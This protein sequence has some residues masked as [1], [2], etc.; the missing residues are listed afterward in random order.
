MYL[1]P[2]LALVSNI[3]NMTI[4]VGFYVLP[5]SIFETGIILGSVIMILVSFLSYSTCCFIIESI[6]RA[7]L[8]DY[9]L[10]YNS[11]ISDL[12]CDSNLNLSTN[13]NIDIKLNACK[14]LNNK[15]TLDNTINKDLINNKKLT[16]YFE[17]DMSIHDAKK[18]TNIVNSYFMNKRIEISELSYKAFKGGTLFYVSSFILTMYLYIGQTAAAL[19]FSNILLGSLETI[20]P[21]LQKDMLYYTLLFVYYF[22]VI[23]LSLKTIDELGKFSS[24]IL[25]CR[26]VIFFILLFSMFWIITNYGIS[27]INKVPLIR[28][29]NSTLML[30]NC[31]FL[32]MLQHSVPGMVYGFKNNKLLFSSF[33][34]GVFISVSVLILYSFITTISFGHH[35]SCDANVFPSAIRNYFNLNFTQVKL[36][37]FFVNFNAF[38][39]IITGAIGCI[40]LTNN[41]KFVYSKVFK[42]KEKSLNNEQNTIIQVIYY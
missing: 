17:I 3:V 33:L 27:P 10:E 28:P 7:N 30:G 5:F 1:S 25:M 39:N 37:S 11:D 13:N 21:N 12:I 31:L 16:N 34:I 32:Y 22:F 2:R 35:N 14:E 24:F 20:F 42:I 8:I 36:V 19:L 23:L 6:S 40:T 15:S 9:C 29:E 18:S 4:G 41:L 26:I 38:L